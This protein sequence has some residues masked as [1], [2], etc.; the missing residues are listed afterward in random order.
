MNETTKIDLLSKNP[1]C[2]SKYEKATT[3][4]PQLRHRLPQSLTSKDFKRYPVAV[5]WKLCLVLG[6]KDHQVTLPS[7]PLSPGRIDSFLYTNPKWGRGTLYPANQYFVGI[8]IPILEPVPS[9]SLSL[10]SVSACVWVRWHWKYRLHRWWIFQESRA[11]WKIHHL[12]SV[13]AVTERGAVVAVLSTVVP[14]A[15]FAYIF[16]FR[17]AVCID[18]CSAIW[19]QSS[20]F[21]I[22]VTAIE[23]LL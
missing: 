10:Y 8:H 18:R 21:I 4:F 23:C 5:T 9:F 7:A 17:Y 1:Q 22:H 14:V 6:I 15:Y 11:V 3:L 16:A 20:A 13:W 19:R 12:G 2:Q